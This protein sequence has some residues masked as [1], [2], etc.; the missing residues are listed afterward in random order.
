MAW[1]LCRFEDGWE[2]KPSGLGIST[3]KANSCLCGP[4]QDFTQIYQVPA[5]CMRKSSMI[6]AVVDIPV[7]PI[8]YFGKFALFMHD[9][10]PFVL[11]ERLLKVKKKIAHRLQFPQTRTSLWRCMALICIVVCI[12]GLCFSTIIWES[13]Y[14][15]PFRVAKVTFSRER[16]LKC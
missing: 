10:L 15:L 14:L 8:S 4:S 11:N 6:R 1:W 13:K 3:F 5:S 12:S 2:L 9:S 16:L 7:V